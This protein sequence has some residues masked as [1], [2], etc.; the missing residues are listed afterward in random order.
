MGIAGPA[1]EYNL[2]PLNKMKGVFHISIRAYMKNTARKN[3]GRIRTKYE[4]PDGGKV[5]NSHKLMGKQ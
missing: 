4:K 2:R 5:N 1:R 3:P